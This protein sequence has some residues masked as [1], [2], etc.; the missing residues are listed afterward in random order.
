MTKP[1]AAIVG[2]THPLAGREDDLDLPG[3]YVREA[4][5]RER[6]VPGDNSLPASSKHRLVIF[7]ERSHRQGSKTV[8]ALGSPFEA[9]RHGQSAEVVGA[10]ASLLGLLGTDE[11]VL[12]GSQPDEAVLGF[13][14]HT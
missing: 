8:E 9:A 5:Q 12:F 2:P 6:R 7:V 13:G 1:K 3:I 10:D 4:P 14:G 11:A